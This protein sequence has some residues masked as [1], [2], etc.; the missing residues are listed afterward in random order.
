[1]FLYII[2]KFRR[3]FVK[4]I[5]IFLLFSHFFESW[6]TWTIKNHLRT[7][8]VTFHMVFSLLPFVRFSFTIFWA[9]FFLLQFHLYLRYD[10]MCVC[11]FFLAPLPFSL[12]SANIHSFYRQKIKKYKEKLNLYL[13]LFI[14]YVF[15]RFVFS[16]SS[17]KCFFPAP[18]WLQNDLSL[19]WCLEVQNRE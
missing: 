18:Q 9:V 8:H 19:S 5:Y 1:M 10:M 13:Y 14:E 15:R 6:R 4:K 11:A 3:Y 2:S 12:S 7:I 17:K 16:V